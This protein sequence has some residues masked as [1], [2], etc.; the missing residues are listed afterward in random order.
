MSPLSLV[1]EGS[2]GKAVASARANG[3]DRPPSRMDYVRLMEWRKLRQA[4]AEPMAAFVTVAT[5]ADYGFL[6][7]RGSASIAPAKA[8]GLFRRFA[9]RMA[10]PEW[11]DAR[12]QAALALTSAVP[13]AA[14]KLVG[15]VTAT[16]S[17]EAAPGA[18]I[19]LAAA[20]GVLEA[21]GIVGGAKSGT[22]VNVSALAQA[23]ADGS[24]DLAAR[25]AADPVASRKYREML[26]ALDAAGAK[27]VDVDGK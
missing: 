16:I 11:E 27:M 12:A 19:N 20:R 26:D 24:H 10:L 3:G 9:R 18:R 2:Y 6:G 7:C 25:I 13:E 4:G 23:S 22:T 21:A 1:S 15:L 8:H 17:A 5:H 14:G